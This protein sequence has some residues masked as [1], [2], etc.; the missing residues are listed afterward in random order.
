M[1]RVMKR[2]VVS[3]EGGGPTFRLR[4]LALVNAGL[5]GLVEHGVKLCLRRELNLVVGL[6]VFLDRLATM[7]G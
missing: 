1:Q 7:E 5:E 4:K 3:C 6:D 2:C